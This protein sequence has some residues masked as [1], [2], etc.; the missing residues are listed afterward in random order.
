MLISRRDPKVSGRG[1]CS[2]LVMGGCLVFL[3]RFLPADGWKEIP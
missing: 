1:I 3:A 2:H